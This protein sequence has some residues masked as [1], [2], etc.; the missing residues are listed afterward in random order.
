M[1]LQQAAK[2]ASESAM[3]KKTMA[4]L[5]ADIKFLDH[6]AFGKL[7]VEDDKRLDKIMGG[8]GLKKAPKS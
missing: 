6:D 1:K 3:F 2:K 4:K 8:L 5:G 7:I